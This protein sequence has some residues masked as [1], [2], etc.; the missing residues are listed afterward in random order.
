MIV[1]DAGY[2]SIDSHVTFCPATPTCQNEKK[3]H[4]PKNEVK[5]LILGNIVCIVS[6][7]WI[8]LLTFVYVLKLFQ[9]FRNIYYFVNLLSS[10][11]I[12]QIL[13]LLSYVAGL[14]VCCSIILKT[15]QFSILSHV[16][17]PLT[18]RCRS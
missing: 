18:I 12:F 4:L 3:K 7:L 1:S 6:C 9:R 16:F 8:L 14:V 2:S 5:R 10:C 13:M 17:S 11:A 15:F